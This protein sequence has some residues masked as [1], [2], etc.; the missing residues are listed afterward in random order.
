MRKR[1]PGQL[2]L[3][4]FYPTQEGCKKQG[5]KSGWIRSEMEQRGDA[6][7]DF[8]VR[9]RTQVSQWPWFGGQAG[10]VIA[11]NSSTSLIQ[12]GG[13][14]SYSSVVRTLDAGFPAL[15]PS[16]DSQRLR[17]LPLARERLTFWTKKVEPT[18]HHLPPQENPCHRTCDERTASRKPQPGTSHQKAK[19]GRAKGEKWVTQPEPGLQV[20]SCLANTC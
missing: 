7:S 19:R 16:A 12:L 18:Q 14:D 11:N 4:L 3:I 2:T 6:N 13:S 9:R 17:Q 1:G 15:T 8:Q 10:E 20:W 5:G